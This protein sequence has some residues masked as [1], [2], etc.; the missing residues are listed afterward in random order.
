MKRPYLNMEQRR[1]IRLD[2]FVGAALKAE[3]AHHQ[4]I[5]A[6]RKDKGT[7]YASAAEREMIKIYGKSITYKNWE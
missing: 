3:L 6:I 4:L 2:T 7:H 1:E 5:K